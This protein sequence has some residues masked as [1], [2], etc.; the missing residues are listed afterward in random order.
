MLLVIKFSVEMRSQVA[1]RHVE[2]LAEPVAAAHQGF[3]LA[4][5]FCL[6]LLQG[7]GSKVDVAII[8]YN[9][10]TIYVPSTSG[11]EITNSLTPKNL[12]TNKSPAV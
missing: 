3:C 7:G 2:T 1:R 4:A 10:I 5:D 6:C 8:K 9:K 11:F 12:S